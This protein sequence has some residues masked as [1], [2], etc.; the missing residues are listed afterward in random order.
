M[1]TRWQGVISV[2]RG[3]EWSTTLGH[4]LIP[5]PTSKVQDNGIKSLPGQANLKNSL[6]ARSQQSK[7]QHTP[8]LSFRETPSQSCPS[9]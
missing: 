8:S 2:S 4:F 6:T 3:L 5:G 1:A 7:N 9:S